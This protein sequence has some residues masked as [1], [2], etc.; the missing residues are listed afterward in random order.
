MNRLITRTS[1]TLT[2]LAIALLAF[3]Q[4][5]AANYCNHSGQDFAN[6]TSRGLSKSCS[7]H[8][9]TSCCSKANGP[10]RLC[11]G[12]DVPPIATG[13]AT[14]DSTLENDPPVD[15]VQSISTIFY[16]RATQDSLAST[17]A[18]NLASGFERCVQLCRYRL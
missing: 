5:L 13:Y 18:I 7:R 11:C 17:A 16:D 14:V 12:E 6:Q 2:L 4:T 9:E 15:A 10:R 8:D 1:K 3:Q